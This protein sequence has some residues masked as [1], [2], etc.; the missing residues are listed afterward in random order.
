MNFVL[1]P[2]SESE[3]SE[4]SESS[5]D[6]NEV[7]Q[8]IIDCGDEEET[9]NEKICPGEDQDISNFEPV[10]KKKNHTSF[11]GDLQSLNQSV[12]NLWEKI[13]H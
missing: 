5:D 4:L 13:L 3:L 2:G 12:Q 11:G 9:D 1:E 10:S 6:E 8:P 7:R